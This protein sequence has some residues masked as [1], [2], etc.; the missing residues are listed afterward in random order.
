MRT[1]GPVC[2]VVGGHGRARY[3]G[4]F[5]VLDDNHGRARGFVAMGVLG[6]VLQCVRP[7]VQRG[8]ACERKCRLLFFQS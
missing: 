7:D 3:Q 6:R 2:R 4:L 8:V 1:G 5:P